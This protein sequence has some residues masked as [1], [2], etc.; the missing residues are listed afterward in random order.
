[1][2]LENGRYAVVNLSSTK[3]PVYEKLVH[4][5][6]HTGGVTAGGKVIGHIHPNELYAII[7]NDS[8]YIT[9]FK[10]CFLDGNNKTRYGYIESSLGIT[11]GDYAWKAKQEP[12][13]FYNSNG[14]K[15]VSST[16][17]TIAGNTYRVF[18]VKKTAKC[19]DPNGDGLPNISPG[20][21]LACKSSTTGKTYPGY[22]VFYYKRSSKNSPWVKIGSNDYAFVNL[23]S[24]FT[25][26]PNNR[27]IW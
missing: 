3:I 14:S 1:M 11:L 26:M 13:H 27:A 6:I 16:K 2:A 18:T 15:L 9:S 7:P 25:T 21:Q 4:G 12:Y 20:T 8:Y 23:F 19:V 5:E 17:T 22:M 10:I 24:A